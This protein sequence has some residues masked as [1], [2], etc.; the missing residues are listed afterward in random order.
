MMK[1][2]ILFLSAL[3][4]LVRPALSQNKLPSEQELFDTLV[5]RGIYAPEVAWQIAIWE[6]GHLKSN[7]CVNH[8]NLF[9][10]RRDKSSYAHFDNWT[11]CVDRFE[12]LWTK[13]YNRYVEAGHKGDAYDFLKWWGYCTGQSNHPRE[14]EYV[15]RLKS[16]RIPKK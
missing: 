14:T 5:A 13:R 7:L 12:T 9:G 2:G 11:D 4:F 3:L 15:A 8:N 1:R 10:L 6:T 16:I